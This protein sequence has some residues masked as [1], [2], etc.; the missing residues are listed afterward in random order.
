MSTSDSPV[1]V[2]PATTPSTTL[3]TGAGAGTDTRSAVRIVKRYNNRK[4]YDTVESRYVTLPQIAELVRL[5]EDVRII[6]NTTKEDLT[7]MTLAQILYEEEKKQ[8]RALPLTA[9]K[10]L[11][12]ASGERFIS[13]LREGPVGKLIGRAE[14]TVEEAPDHPGEAPHPPAESVTTVAT[15]G[16]G[17][18]GA[19]AGGAVEGA[20]PTT[21]VQQLVEQS[22]GALD[23]WQHRVDERVKAF[24]ETINPAVQIQTLQAEVRRLQ[25][26][27]EELE[28][29][30]IGREGGE[31][32][33]GRLP[34]TEKE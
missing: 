5:G 14:S 33:A 20:H 13:T 29:R 32:P 28:G 27:V 15:A 7:S 8:S 2:A 23:Q 34:P 31:G 25:A 11:L 21:R 24:W 19:G 9:L 18:S 1:P 22:R 6:D 30:L 12:H 4:L 26:R 3:G 10:D 16:S 17:A